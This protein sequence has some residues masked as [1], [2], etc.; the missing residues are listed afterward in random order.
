MKFDLQHFLE[1]PES[2]DEV[3]LEALPAL[4]VDI[5]ALLARLASTQARIAARL[6]MLS[7]AE[8]N[9]NEDRLID[10]RAA[11]D[12]LGLKRAYLY[13]L[14]REDRFPAVRVGKYVRIRVGDMKTWVRRATTTTPAPDASAR[15]CV[16]R[17][18]GPRG[19]MR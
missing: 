4:L 13:A 12:Y 1:S 11:A 8:H 17:L 2:V 19:R 7:E 14:I 9:P 6:R 5:S 10:I 3:S 18:A 15:E 16:R